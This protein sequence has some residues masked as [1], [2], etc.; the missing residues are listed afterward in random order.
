MDITFDPKKRD[1]TLQERGLDFADAAQVFAGKTLDHDDERYDYGERRIITVGKLLGRMVIVAWTPRRAARHV[2]S[3]RK[4][5]A[6][7][8]KRYGQRLEES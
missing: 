1:A 7:E 2:F 6:K 5:N 8:Q 3:M 4:A